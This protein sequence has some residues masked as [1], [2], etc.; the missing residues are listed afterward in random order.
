MTLIRPELVHRLRPWRE[1]IAAA[2]TALA[3][4]WV[5]SLG[6]LVFRPLGLAIGAVAV[7]WGLGAWR[8]RSFARDVAAPGLVEVDEGA[9]RFYAARALG[10]EIALRDVTE[11]R[12]LRLNGRANWRLKTQA[13]E[14]L[15][16]P[17]DAAGAAALADAFA[18]LPG[19]DLGRAA[20]AL[21][22]TAAVSTIWKRK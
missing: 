15:L 14:A 9:I 20:S 18:A 2:L 19:F 4:L 10:G 5:F 8:R 13:G 21:A 6:G 12:L 11:I 16:I 17:T 3:G 22:G 7:V 1:V